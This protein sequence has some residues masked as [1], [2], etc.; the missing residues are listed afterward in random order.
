MSCFHPLHAFKIG[1][2]ANGKDKYKITSG[3]IERIEHIVNGKVALGVWN[4]NYI[5]VPCGKCIGCR[6]DYSRQW[7]NRCMLEARQYEH[8]AFIT[9]TYED[10][11]LTFNDGANRKTGEVMKVPTLVPEELTKFMKDLRRYYKYHYGEENIRFYACGEYG[12]KND[13][14]HFHI[15]AFNINVRD[16]EYLFTNKSHDKIYTSEII[17]NIWGKGHVTIGEVTWNSAAYTARYVMK[18]IKGKD[19]KKY[20]EI[21][22]VAP[23]FTR[24]SR[25][26]GIARE[27]YEQNKEKIFE[28]DEIILANKKG[29]AQKIKPCKYYDNLYDI[30]N[31]EFMKALKQRRKLEAEYTLAVQLGKTDLT[32]QEYMELKERKKIS[33]VEKLK[34]A[35]T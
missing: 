14:P 4:T 34:R 1:I 28:L 3:D 35:L 23:E 10:T 27:Y 16:K 30:E 22:G 18:K 5:E 12:S 8:N 11:A 7:A 21:L 2:T 25:R 26:Q 13:R 32:K 29:V 6:L 24:M 20:Y 31:H 19:A 9:L 33:Q 15:I 17:R